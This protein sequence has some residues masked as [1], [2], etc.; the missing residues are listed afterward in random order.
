MSVLTDTKK[1]DAL[2][3][4]WLEQRLAKLR[5]EFKNAQTTMIAIDGAI[6]LAEEQLRELN[7]EDDPKSSE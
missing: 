1:P 5:E 7:R 4:E 3:R 2:S 6:Q